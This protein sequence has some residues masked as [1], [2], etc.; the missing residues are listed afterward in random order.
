MVLGEAC[1]RSPRT[2]SRIL[3]TAQKYVTGVAAEQ[4]SNLKLDCADM[5]H[6]LSS[7]RLD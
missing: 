2:L 1:V 4:R 3:P 6:D 5:S 7:H